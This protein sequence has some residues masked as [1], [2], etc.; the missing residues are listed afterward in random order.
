M[1]CSGK[2]IAIAAAVPDNLQF[3]QDIRCHHLPIHVR[4]FNGANR[5]DLT[6]FAIAVTTGEL[7]EFGLSLAA[8]GRLLSRIDM[9]YLSHKTEQ[10]E[11]HQINDLIILVPKRDDYDEEFPTT[12]T[13]WDEVKN[14]G[15][16]ENLNFIP[17]SIGDLLKAKIRGEW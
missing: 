7:R 13:S 14:F 4:K 10:L 8:I 9:D 12:V 16:D 3:M 15:R 17:C 2:E 6:S 5:D 1:K 11:L